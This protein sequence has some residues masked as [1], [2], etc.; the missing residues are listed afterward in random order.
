MNKRK[1]IVVVVGLLALVSAALISYKIFSKDKDLLDTVIVD[2]TFDE[3]LA[4]VS[5]VMTE[6]ECQIFSVTM[7]KMV[8]GGEKVEG[9]T[10][11]QV[12]EKGKQNEAD[13]MKK[14]ESDMGD[15]FVRDSLIKDSLRRDSIEQSKK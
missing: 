5:K 14:V 10:Y 15:F 3:D 8:L 6:E 9:L 4:R 7:W 2:A 1:L 12:L 13:F 11:R